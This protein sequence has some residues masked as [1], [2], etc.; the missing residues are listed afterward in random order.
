MERSTKSAAALLALAGALFATAAVADMGPGGKGGH[1]G[2]GAMLIQQFD[3]IDADKDGKITAAELAAHRQARFTAADT[4]SDGSLNAE[5]LTAFHTAQMAERMAERTGR[6]MQWMDANG[7][8]ALSVDEMPDGPSPE[9][10][11]RI[12]IDGDGAISREEAQAAGERM[13]GQM[14]KHRKGMG[15]N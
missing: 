12:D 14:Q 4:N 11:A 9:R 3:E 7:D 10:M 2:R 13:A 6:M 1:E 15:D 8:G 5:E